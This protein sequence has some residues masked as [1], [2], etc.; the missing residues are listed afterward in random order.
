MAV[1][2]ELSGEDTIAAIA[3]GITES[4]IGIIRV[5]GPCAFEIG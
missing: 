2:S 4:G 1:H 5:S 3:T